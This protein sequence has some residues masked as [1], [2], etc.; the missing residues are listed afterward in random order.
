MLQVART[1]IACTMRMASVHRGLRVNT[2]KLT[3]RNGSSMPNQ[4]QKQQF[5]KL[6]CYN[7]CE[8]L[9]ILDMLVRH[10]DSIG[11]KVVDEKWNIKYRITTVELITEK[12]N[13]D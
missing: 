10:W 13:E 6:V 11:M 4:K 9:Q 3:K 1:L 2:M 12:Q 7:T 5:H 8:A